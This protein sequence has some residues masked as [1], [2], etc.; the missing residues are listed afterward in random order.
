MGKKPLTKAENECVVDV[1]STFLDFEARTGKRINR[2]VV[3]EKLVEVFKGLVLP[4][5]RL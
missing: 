4:H 2:Q 3:R 5:K 1:V